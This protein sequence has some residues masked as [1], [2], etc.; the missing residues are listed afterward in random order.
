MELYLVRHAVTGANLSYRL[1]GRS[2]PPLHALGRRSARQLGRRLRHEPIVCIA[3]SPLKRAVQTAEAIRLAYTPKY[4]PP[5]VIDRDLREIDLGEI[6]GMSAFDAYVSHR[7]LLERALAPDAPDTFAFPGGER[8]N[9]ALGRFDHALQT[10][11]KA[12]P[13][14]HVAVITH[15]GPIGLF[16]AR[17]FGQPLAAFRSLTPQHASLT[18]LRL[19]GDQPV[20]LLEQEGV[21]HL[22]A[23]L[24][25]AIE[26]SRAAHR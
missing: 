20:L 10:L 9:D 8:R 24:L 26:Q 5:L 11:L 15:G 14:G 12:Y 2:D 3:C 18:R 13:D 22:S 7:D 19:E 4:R 23:S 6:D 25:L 1:I 17:L 21:R 16:L